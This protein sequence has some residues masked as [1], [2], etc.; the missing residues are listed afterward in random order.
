MYKLVTKFTNKYKNKYI[1]AVEK[2]YKETGEDCLIV[3]D[4]AFLNNGKE[5]I[6]SGALYTSKQK[7]LSRFWKIFNNITKY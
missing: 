4:K 5:D 1:K 6:T 3:S 2:Y 7:D